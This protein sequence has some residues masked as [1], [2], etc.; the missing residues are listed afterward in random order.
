[1]SQSEVHAPFGVDEKF[2]VE[3][4]KAGAGCVVSSFDPYMYDFYG[5]AEAILK[6]LDA[7]GLLLDERRMFMLTVQ[8]ETG[9][10]VKLFEKVEDTTWNVRTWRGENADEIHANIREM[11][12]RNKGVFCT[13]EQ[14]KGIFHKMELEFSEDTNAPAPYSPRAAFGHPI[15]AYTKEGYGRASV[16]CFC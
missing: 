4:S 6:N 15:R 12:F 9:A 11:L 5:D 10:E 7:S 16:T 3:T 13:G 1:M 2:L 8:S 14:A